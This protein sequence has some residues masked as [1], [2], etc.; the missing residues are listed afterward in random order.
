M[1]QSIFF[2]LWFYG[3]KF[4]PAGIM[5][6]SLYTAALSNLCP[7]LAGVPTDC[8]LVYPAVAQNQTVTHLWQGW[9]SNLSSLTALQ[10]ASCLLWVGHLIMIS[11]GF[12][13]RESP[14]WRE[15]PFRNR[16]WALA[17]LIV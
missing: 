2:I 1:F 17:V 14:I 12:V 4:V 5:L 15:S 7:L 6:L 10:H 9:G 16:V 13:H 3:S 11:I 8:S